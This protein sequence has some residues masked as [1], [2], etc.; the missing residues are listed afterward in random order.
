MSTSKFEQLCE[1][2]LNESNMKGLPVEHGSP[3]Y[4]MEATI[5]KVDKT[6]I[7]LSDDTN[8]DL[9]KKEMAKFVET[10]LW[11][12]KVVGGDAFVAIAQNPDDYP[13][14]FEYLNEM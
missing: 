5:K 10:G 7:Y 11:V 14:A 6:T 1:S 4:P 12:G 9:D 8:Y 3:G 13:E 2:V